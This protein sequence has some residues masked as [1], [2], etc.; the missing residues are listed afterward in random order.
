M[1]LQITDR[2]GEMGLSFHWKPKFKFPPDR[3]FALRGRRIQVLDLQMRFLERFPKILS[4]FT[5]ID[6]C[7]DCASSSPRADH[8][9]YHLLQNPRNHHPV[10]WIYR[11]C[12]QCGFLLAKQC[13]SIRMGTSVPSS[14]QGLGPWAKRHFN[15]VRM[16]FGKLDGPSSR[17]RQGPR[18]GAGRGRPWSV[19]REQRSIC[20]KAWCYS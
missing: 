8:I 16:V 9:L 11:H 4:G 10:A 13:D 5:I 19:F 15:A 18:T 12:H 14:F 20:Y 17:A 2:Q 7:N 6:P 1:S 3:Q